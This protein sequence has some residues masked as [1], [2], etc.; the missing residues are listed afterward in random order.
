MCTYIY[1]YMYTYIYIH[2][3]YEH[4]PLVADQLRFLVFGLLYLHTAIMI[5]HIISGSHTSGAK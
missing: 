4:T 3:T 1:T 2:Y 5:P